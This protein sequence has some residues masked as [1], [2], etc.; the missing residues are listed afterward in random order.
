MAACNDRGGNVQSKMAFRRSDEG[1]VVVVARDSSVLGG[2]TADRNIARQMIGASLKKLIGVSTETDAWRTIISPA[3]TVGIKV[4]CLGGPK[5]CTR[6]EL[7]AA[8]IESLTKSVG[9]PS[10]HIIIWD[11][12]NRE[13]ERCGYKLATDG[14]GPLCFGTDDRRAGYESEPRIYGSIGSC[15]STILT[16]LCTA[17][18]NVPI[19]KDHDLAGVSIGM[20]NFYG[21]IHN[22][23]KYHDNCCDPYIAD[24]NTAPPI[25]SKL[26]LTVCDAI[27]PQYH[28]GPAYKKQFVWPF[29]G[30][31]MARDPVA[32]DATGARIIETERKTRGKPSLADQ[33]RDPAYIQTAENKGLGWAREDK[34]RVME[35]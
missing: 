13:L 2:D 10:N 19:L 29:A 34:V 26:R 28:G 17:I 31:I 12:F 30:I 21:V 35:V 9:I 27:T 7:V 22:P 18:I 8:L 15:F 6:P 24:L 25:R 14:S 23:N 20:K 3:D 1:S 4:N 5:M 11:R 32:L 16:R 33:E